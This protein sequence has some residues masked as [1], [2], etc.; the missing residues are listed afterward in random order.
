[1]LINEMKKGDVVDGA[2]LIKEVSVRP[3]KNNSQE[4]LYFLLSD[5]S[6]EI[7][8][9]IWECTPEQKEMFSIGMVVQVKGDVRE[10]QGKL[11]LNI[12]EISVDTE[13]SP[14]WFIP[15][16]SVDVEGLWGEMME[17]V[18]DIRHEKLREM[19]MGILADHREAFMR[20]PAAKGMHHA[21][22]GGLLFHVATMLRMADGVV[23]VYP[24]LNKDLLYAGI[25]LHDLGK[26]YE[27]DSDQYGIVRSYTVEGT[28]LGHIIQGITLIDRYAAQYDL[29]HETTVLLQHMVLSHHYHPEWGSPKPP[30][31]PEAEILFYLDMI[32][33]RMY[34]IFDA[35]S[36]AKKSFTEPIRAMEGR[37]MYVPSYLDMGLGRT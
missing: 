22:R 37:R 25:V 9:V 36:K 21:I 13:S 35:F 17:R 2:Y 6:G 5:K 20:W 8:A 34:A 33:A 26:I 23:R 12:K 31:I 24:S 4:F 30:M 1:M 16:P 28:L 3:A 27:M 10:W 29:D 32:D 15:G 11:Q 19:V 14:E 18:Q 7:N